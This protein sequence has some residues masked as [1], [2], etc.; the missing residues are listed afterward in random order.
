LQPFEVPG[1]DSPPL[2]LARHEPVDAEDKEKKKSLSHGMDEECENTNTISLKLVIQ[3]IFIPLDENF[4]FFS[5]SK[6]TFMFIAFT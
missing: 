4:S 2:P 1:G 5:F 3:T 6:Q